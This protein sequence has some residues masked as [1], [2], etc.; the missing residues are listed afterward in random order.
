MLWI[1]AATRN[2][3]PALLFGLGTIGADLILL[4][5]ALLVAHMPGIAD[6]ARLLYP[7]FI[8]L[9]VYLGVDSLLTTLRSVEAS[10]LDTR[11][12]QR[13]ESQSLVYVIRGILLGVMN[14]VQVSWWIVA[15][16]ALVARNSGVALAVFLGEV[17]WMVFYVAVLG[18]LTRN[19]KLRR[20]LGLASAILLLALAV[21]YA[22]SS[23]PRM[24]YGL[25]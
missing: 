19:A 9:L 14:P 22:V 12:H 18:L 16:S 10:R 1:R 25:G 8:A 11:E 21:Y 15:G 3:L 20:L 6:H 4:L 23:L 7:I 17:F 5:V 13:V 2:W 24:V